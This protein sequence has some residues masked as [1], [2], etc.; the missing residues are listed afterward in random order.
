M[1][2][3]TTRRRF[4]CEAIATAPAVWLFG[5]AARVAGLAAIR[6][7]VPSADQLAWQDMEIGMF[8]HFA[9][10]TFQ[11]KEY[12]DLSTPLSQIDPDIDTDNWAQCAVNPLPVPHNLPQRLA[13]RHRSQS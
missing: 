13:K 8:V 1:P 3:A 9:P 2:T 4:L 12:D 7:A 11:D 5:I 10:N 6:D